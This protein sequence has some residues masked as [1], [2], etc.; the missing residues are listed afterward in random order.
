MPEYDRNMTGVLFNAM[1]KKGD[2][3]RKPDYTGS[4][5]VDGVEYRLSAW[6]RTAKQ[7]SKIEGQKYMSL[8]FTR[9]DADPVAEPP[10]QEVAQSDIPF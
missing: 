2:N 5:T 3:E 10:K 1:A 4:A 6:I 7:G 9:P 8:S